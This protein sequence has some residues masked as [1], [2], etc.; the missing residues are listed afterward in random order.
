M[1]AKELRIGNLLVTLEGVLT[2]VD[3]LMI[4]ELSQCEAA[5]NTG[6]F[7]Y[8]PIPLSPELL[9]K[10]GFYTFGY[11]DNYFYHA[12]LTPHVVKWDNGYTLEAVDDIHIADI[13][14]HFH[15]LQNIFFWLTDKELEDN[16]VNIDSN[17]RT[18]KNGEPY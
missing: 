16:W 3:A 6:A 17:I 14:Y 4:M 7:R 9:S 11:H 5:K 18:E 12:E 13:F 15:Q 1:K 8:S 10:C 2:K